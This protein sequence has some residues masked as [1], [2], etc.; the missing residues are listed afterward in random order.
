MWFTPQKRACYGKLFPDLSRR[1]E[2]NQPRGGAVFGCTAHGAGGAKSVS[3]TVDDAKWEQC[4]D[5]ARYRS[6]YDLSVAKLLLQTGVPTRAET[7]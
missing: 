3:V 1:L 6:C 2:P 7:R 5:C 4:V